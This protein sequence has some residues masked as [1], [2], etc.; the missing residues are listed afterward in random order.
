[1]GFRR[2]NSRKRHK[3]LAGM[4]NSRPQPF[5]RNNDGLAVSLC[6]LATG[7][8]ISHRDQ[9][10]PWSCD[11]LVG[12]SEMPCG[13]SGLKSL[14]TTQHCPPLPLPALQGCLYLHLPP[15]L[16][17][18][19]SARS[20]RDVDGN[21]PNIRSRRFSNIRERIP[22]RLR[23]KRLL[24]VRGTR[25]RWEGGA[26]RRAPQVRRQG[27]GGSCASAAVWGSNLITD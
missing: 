3:C 18:H 27:A 11:T 20:R 25:R 24:H 10:G 23:G 21:E 17:A 5:S 14:G 9:L 2:L 7:G 1:M 8:A 6:P 19:R 16:P 12:T 22:R 15:P 13:K 26:L 4:K